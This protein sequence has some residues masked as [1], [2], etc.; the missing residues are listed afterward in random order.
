MRHP[1][2]VHYVTPATAGPAATWRPMGPRGCHRRQRCSRSS[3]QWALHI[4]RG[5]HT[6]GELRRRAKGPS[7][8]RLALGC[9]MCLVS[10][11]L[12]FLFAVVPVR[13]ACIRYNPHSGTPCPQ[14]TRSFGCD[15]HSQQSK[16]GLVT[17]VF[18]RIRML[19]AG[20]PG[21]ANVDALLLVHPPAMVNILLL[22]S[23]RLL[24]VHSFSP[25]GYA[26]RVCLQAMNWAAVG[27]APCRVLRRIACSSDG[28]CTDRTLDR[29]PC[30]DCTYNVEWTVQRRPCSN[31]QLSRHSTP[32]PR[33]GKARVHRWAVPSQ[34]V[35]HGGDP[36]DN[37]ESAASLRLARAFPP[38]RW[39]RVDLQAVTQRQEQFY[40]ER[41]DVARADEIYPVR[42]HSPTIQLRSQPKSNAIQ[43][44]RI[45]RAPFGHRIVLY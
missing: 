40:Y 32:K 43:C 19:L 26:S 4:N 45:G 2:P 36:A 1:V 41:A 17:E 31:A 9:I 3:P 21:H 15:N 44:G 14:F 27:R 11:F 7:S 22:S 10:L 5:A 30:N 18:T 16:G 12:A 8:A 24:L 33:Q 28:R 13:R 35:L 23:L 39:G 6:R 20:D 38:D 29:L 34:V 37:A 25:R 42:R